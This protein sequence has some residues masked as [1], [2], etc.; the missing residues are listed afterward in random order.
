VKIPPSGQQVEIRFGGQRATVVEVGG[1]LREFEVDGWPVVDG[2][3]VSLPASWGRG[4]LLLPWPNR[5]PEGQYPLDGEVQQLPLN[6]PQHSVAIHGLTRWSGW[7]L[8]QPAADRVTAEHVLFPQPGYPCALHCRADYRLGPDGLT[9]EMSLTNMSDRPA[10][11]GMGAHPYL[12]G[13]ADGV[14]GADLRIPA[15]TRLITDDRGIPT[16]RTTVDGTDRD[17]RE[18]RRIGTA[19]IDAPFTDLDRDS[20]GLARARFVVP[21][22][23]EVTVWV[24]EVWSHLQVFTGDTMPADQR[25]RS[26][27]VEPM[28]CA[29]NAFN[30]GEGLR[31][32]A[33]AETLSGTWGMSATVG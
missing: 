17:F 9:V 12:Q 6:E 14:D 24:D 21:G 19:V 20:D 29:P 2:Y 25:R 15:R 23:A 32:L 18:L 10:P 11:V 33:P 31:W 1:G 5:I 13:G 3:D 30:T 27:A 8:D 26:V 28:T 22:R 4:Q 7:Q 16:D